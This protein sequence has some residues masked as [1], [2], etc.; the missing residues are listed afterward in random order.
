MRKQ[1]KGEI[2]HSYINTFLRNKAEASG[3][4]ADVKM[5]DD[6]KLY[7]NE[8]KKQEGILLEQKNI[9]HNP[10]LRSLAKLALNSFYGQFGQRVNMKKCVFFFTQAE[11]IYNLLIDYSKKVS[12]FHVINENFVV[13][14]YTKKQGFME[15]NNRTNV[16]VATF[17]TSYARMKLWKLMRSLKGRV[18][19]HDTDSVIY[20]YTPKNTCPPIGKCFG[21]LTDELTCDNVGCSDCQ[22][23]HWI[24]EPISCGPKN[25]GYRLNTGQITCAVRG[26]SLNY[27][28]SQTLNLNSMKEALEC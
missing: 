6:R 4:P 24:V 19:Y 10:G 11:D 9:K 12:D 28:A 14:E 2:F 23:G 21:Q 7:I 15:V 17:C 3:F 13:M 22:E 1:R 16:T 26:F 25:Y 18:L 8:F 27:N 5:D 20:S